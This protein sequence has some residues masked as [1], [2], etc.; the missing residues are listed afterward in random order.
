MAQN[1][2]HLAIIDEVQK[3]A[4]KYMSPSPVRPRGLPLITNELL[5]TS[6]VLGKRTSNILMLKQK[7]LKTILEHKSQKTPNSKQKT[8][9]YSFPRIKNRDKF[10]R[11]LGDFLSS[12]L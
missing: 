7:G 10:T 6:N 9:L 11:T 4:V 5:K 1:Q 12:N 8:G 2:D 3:S